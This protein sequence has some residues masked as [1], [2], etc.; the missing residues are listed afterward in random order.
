MF[1]TPFLGAFDVDLLPM[2]VNMK[3]LDISECTK[4]DADKF[5]EHIGSC[6]EV[7]QLNMDGCTQFTPLQ[8][9][10]ICCSLPKLKHLSA[11]RC[12]PLISVHAYKIADS[13]PNMI[14]LK[15]EPK[16]LKEDKWN[17]SQV[18]NIF[19]DTNFGPKVK[20]Y[21]KTKNLSLK[22]KN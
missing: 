13:H 22:L 7:M 17:W 18:V 16:W 12:K 2:F 3:V 6:K 21:V 14:A 11:L 15:V 20:A 1:L 8:I 9:I 5:T 10:E 19:M 4:I